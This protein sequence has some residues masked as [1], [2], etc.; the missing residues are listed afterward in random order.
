MAGIPLTA[1]F[2]GKYF[3]FNSVVSQG[4]TLLIV[5]AVLSSLISVYYYLRVIVFMF[6]KEEKRAHVLEF[7]IGP[8]LVVAL[9]VILTLQFGIFPRSV[10]SFF[11][12][13]TQ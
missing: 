5:I 6:M 7:S 8:V 11:A 9:M 13:V 2:I 12:K 4:E 10:M 3:L 1:G